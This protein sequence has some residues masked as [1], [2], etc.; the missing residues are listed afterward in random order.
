MQITN[1]RTHSPRAGGGNDNALPEHN[2][3]SSLVVCFDPKADKLQSSRFVRFV[4][5]ADISAPLRPVADP[6]RHAA[7]TA[8]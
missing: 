1:V 8:R 3:E 2:I 7:P 5:L 6:R 4:P